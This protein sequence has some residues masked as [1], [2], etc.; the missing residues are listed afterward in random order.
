[1]KILV[2]ENIPRISVNALAAIGHDVRDVRG[3]PDEG[4]VDDALWNLAQREQRLLITTDRGFARRRADFHHGI[5]IITLRRPN[6]LA[7][8]SRI[9]AALE[10]YGESVWRGLLV[11]VRDRAQSRWRANQ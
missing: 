10:E 2:D 8:H 1:M 11:I 6:H 5:L 9:M 4:I 3:T 7:I